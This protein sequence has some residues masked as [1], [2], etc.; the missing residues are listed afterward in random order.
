MTP[1]VVTA[2]PPTLKRPTLTNPTVLKLDAANQSRSLRLRDSDYLIVLPPD[3]WT[4]GLELRGGRD[5]LVT[6]GYL[7][8]G[9]GQDNPNINIGPGT[10]NVER[11]IHLEGL[12]I[13]G[14]GG[15]RSD[16]F[17]IGSSPGTHVQLLKNRVTTLRG[18]L[19]TTHAD[20][21]QNLGAESLRV[22][23]LT[24]RSHYNNIYARRENDPLGRR[25]GPMYFNKV[26]T[27]GYKTNP[28]AGPHDPQHT[29]RGL[30]LGTQGIPPSDPT[31]P[32]QKNLTGAVWLHEY[33]TNLVLES[34]VPVDQVV[35]PHAGARMAAS[36]RAVVRDNYVY[37]PV[38][39]TS[40]VPPEDETVPSKGDGS[41]SGDAKVYG[42]VRIGAPVQG[43]YVRA[44]DVGLNYPMSLRAAA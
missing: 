44:H 40:T 15:G 12:L 24:S 28:D 17:H 27:G 41:G 4:A 29:L 10:S 35:Y 32:V 19:S 2:A 22:E 26:N 11:I 37:W 38:W 23:E 20:V 6:G 5:I 42:V 43:D 3:P 18:S 7:S 14:R 34:G 36:C 13:D 33:Y 25:V 31:L 8:T 1:I 21:I 16:A 30:S 9:P 39:E